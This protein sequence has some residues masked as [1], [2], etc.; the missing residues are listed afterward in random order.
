MEADA[1]IVFLDSVEYQLEPKDDLAREM[2]NI[3]DVQN[4]V[5]V[6]ARTGAGVKIAIA[7]SGFD[8]T[9][10]DLPVPV[11]TYD[12]TDGVGVANGP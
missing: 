1:K 7:D 11:E 12:V 2:V 9:H 10:A 6:V 4:G 5:G 3:D 8:L